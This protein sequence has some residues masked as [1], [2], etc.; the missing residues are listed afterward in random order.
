M[1]QSNMTG[2]DVVSDVS[3][4]KVA[5]RIVSFFCS[6]KDGYVHGNKQSIFRPSFPSYCMGC[7]VALSSSHLETSSAHIFFTSYVAFNG[8]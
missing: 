5:P 6:G 2:G 4:D 7:A 8:K 1:K 3:N